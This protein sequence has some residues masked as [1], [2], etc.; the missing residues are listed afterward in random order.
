MLF[1]TRSWDN[2]MSQVNAKNIDGLIQIL[3]HSNIDTSQW[4]KGKYQNNQ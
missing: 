1:Q 4:G 3:K 2:T